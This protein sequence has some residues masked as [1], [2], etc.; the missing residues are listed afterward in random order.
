MRTLY[1]L[2]YRN[3]HDAALARIDALEQEL[4]GAREDAQ[5]KSARDHDRI[6]MLEREIAD[7]RRGKEPAPRPPPIVDAVVTS[8]KHVD[9]RVDDPLPIPPDRGP[10]ISKGLLALLIMF[11]TVIAG[12]VIVLVR[13]ST[14]PPACVVET[15]VP[16]QLF[17]IDDHGETYLGNT[18]ATVQA[19]WSHY[20]RFELRSDGYGTLAIPAPVTASGT[21]SSSTFTLYPR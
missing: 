21:C 4:A 14:K 19:K 9:V 12:T 17:G 16:A 18:P 1:V 8:P 3:D 20:T 13:G 2:S 15:S 7:L 6:A 5:E 10:A 11:A